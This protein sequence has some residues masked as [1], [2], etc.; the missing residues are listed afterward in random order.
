M[1]FI[2]VTAT[3]GTTT[4][5]QYWNQQIISAS[6]SN[7]YYNQGYV[8]IG[9]PLPKATLHSVGSGSFG[10]QFATS[11]IPTDCL[12][13]SSNVGIGT[14]TPIAKLDVRG[15]LYCPGMPVQ[16]VTAKINTDT[17]IPNNST[18]T[19]TAVSAS[20]TPRFANSLIMVQM[21]V[22]FYAVNSS[23]V[24]GMAF[25]I[26]KDGVADTTAVGTQSTGTQAL[27]YT[28]DGAVYNKVPLMSTYL[29]GSTATTTM[30]CYALNNTWDA[31][32]ASAGTG[33]GWGRS[34]VIITEIAQ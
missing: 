30:T 4:V 32:A 8:G 21:N 2:R 13:V 28:Q 6:Q 24:S 12:C 9:V 23:A 10:S 16:I 5:P 20:I 1:S 33:N 34:E 3:S 15:S 19:A 25:Q 22:M 11:N 27:C 31:T 7:V 26:R 18:W 17:T 14:A 29:P